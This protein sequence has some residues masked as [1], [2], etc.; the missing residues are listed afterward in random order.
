MYIWLQPY[1]HIG[2]IVSPLPLSPRMLY[3]G[4]R[5]LFSF[6]SLFS[7]LSQATV[8]YTKPSP[9]ASNPPSNACSSFMTRQ[10]HHHH[11]YYRTNCVGCSFIHSSKIS[12]IKKFAIDYGFYL[13]GSIFTYSHKKYATCNN[14]GQCCYSHSVF[15]QKEYGFAEPENS[16]PLYLKILQSW[17]VDI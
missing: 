9:L 8:M 17:V 5:C 14:Y 1:L 2:Q 3:H 7:I 12:I 10:Q 16:I 6:C 13:E 11:K 4:I 15:G